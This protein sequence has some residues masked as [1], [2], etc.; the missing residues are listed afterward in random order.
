[1][2]DLNMDDI[3][4]PEDDKIEFSDKPKAE[5]EPEPAKDPAAESAPP[6]E[7]KCEG[8]GEG[9]GGE[10]PPKQP[11]R[12]RN[13][14]TFSERIGEYAKRALTAEE[15]KAA[16]QARADLL[17]R[18]LKEISARHQTASEQTLSQREQ[19]A[20]ARKQKA[21]EEQD[22]AA[23]DAAQNDLVEIKLARRTP[24]D[25][26]AIPEPKPST[27]AEPEPIH[28]SAKAWIDRNSWFSNKDH[29]HL[30]AEAMRIEARLRQSGMQLG[31]ELYKK[32]DEEL[33]DLPDF[34]EVR[35]VKADDPPQV[36][37]P[38]DPVPP[39][40]SPVSSS[41]SDAPPPPKPRPNALTEHDKRTMRTYKL[42]PDNPK[43]RETYLQYKTK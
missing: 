21:I 17:E 34:D 43:H 20:M 32:L 41:R 13:K 26:P 16:A 36:D 18:Q 37:P 6:D 22:F 8:E 29:Q 33:A 19:D 30:A 35:G 7:P 12:K 9:E 1:M 27:P 28:T 4:I 5:Q 23:Y 3:T 14:K 24:E 40:R 15:E 39:P 11:E 31:D 42:D 38:A 25:K 10:Q 2:N